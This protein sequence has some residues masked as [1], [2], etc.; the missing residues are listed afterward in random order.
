MEAVEE[1]LFKMN[2]LDEANAKRG[3]PEKRMLKQYNAFRLQVCG[4]KRMR[5]A[6]ASCLQ[7]KTEGRRRLPADVLRAEM[8]SW[9]AIGFGRSNHQ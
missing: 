1:K 6:C 9:E 5:C 8:A 2:P 7:K 4:G 3:T